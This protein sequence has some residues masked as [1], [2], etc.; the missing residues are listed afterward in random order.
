MQ[1]AQLFV[2]VAV[3]YVAIGL[4][5]G[6]AFVTRGVQRID[7]GADGGSVLFRLLILPGSIA[8]WPPAPASL[9]DLE[10]RSRRAHGA[11]PRQPKDIP[12]VMIR[13]L[14]QRHRAMW[15]FLAIA[16]P[17]AFV[18]SLLAR[19]DQVVMDSLPGEL[20]DYTTPARS[21]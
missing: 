2:T 10:S 20:T 3:I 1:T 17:A 8:F 13:S 16:L 21:E 12:V 4:L 18:V 9:A 6:L 15:W 5:F 14:R 11:S 19:P 7:T